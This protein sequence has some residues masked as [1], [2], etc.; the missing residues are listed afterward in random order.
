MSD[1]S[2]G[3]RSNTGRDPSLSLLWRISDD[4]LDPG[5]REAQVHVG[6]G[7]QKRW[8]HSVVLAA[9]LLVL[10]ALVTAAALQTVRGAPAANRTRDDLAAR[11][12]D[13]SQQ[14][15]A[16]RASL[17]QMGAEVSQ[18]RVE[19]LS[20]SET[21]RQL[22]DELLAYELASGLVAVTGPGVTVELTD[23][24]PT[25][26]T[27]D[28]GGADLAKVLDRDLQVVVNGLF[29]SGAEAVSVNGQRITALS[30]IRGAGGAVLVGYRPLSP[31]YVV[32]AIG[33]PETLES[34]F[35]ASEAAEEMRTIAATY[36]IGFATQ[37]SDS[38]TVPA[39]SDLSLRYAEPRR[40]Q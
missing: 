18:L 2:L 32:N 8:G 14:V 24:P 36:G 16:A 15:D 13:A 27:G 40:N 31:P 23:G 39:E 1:A 30:A 34:Q 26:G 37:E 28:T 10:A 5:Y 25:A 35:A 6:A 11:V 22:R 12:T 7:E 4:A 21:D 29:A 38:I 19:A 3:L 33:S 20:G 9:A 17:A